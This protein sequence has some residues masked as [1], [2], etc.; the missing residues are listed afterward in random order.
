M[1]D[2]KYLKSGGHWRRW[3]IGLAVVAVVVA[4]LPLLFG[5]PFAV[6]VMTQMGIAIVFALSYNMLL[7]QGGMLSFGHAV[8]F[9]FGGYF[10]IHV[11]NYLSDSGVPIPLPFLPVFG[12]L[13]GLLLGLCLGSFSTRRAGTVFAM[14]SLGLG[15][16]MFSAGN[17]F[18]RFF[19]GEEGI[20][21]DRT[22]PVEFFGFN[23]AREIQVYYLVAFWVLAAGF[24]I[25]L[26]TRTPVGRLSNAV[27]DNEERLEFIGYSQRNI[28]LITLAGS[29]LFA[30]IAGS[31]T[32]IAY[33]ILTVEALSGHTSGNVLV[34]TFLGG[35]GVFFGPI[36][37]A[38]VLNL[39]STVL[40]TL[41]T[42][43]LL[44]LGILFLFIVLFL[45]GG[46]ASLIMMH[47]P[48][49]ATGRLKSLLVPYLMA[50]L[51]G[52]ILL[53]GL[54]GLLEMAHFAKFAAVGNTTMEFLGWVLDIET[55]LPW[56]LF[57]GLAV[58]GV[59]LIKKHIPVVAAAYHDAVTGGIAQDAKGK[60]GEAEA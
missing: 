47:R 27:R 29:G 51:Y 12:G 9:G 60:V 55:V 13:A 41:T 25:Y 44:Y 19:G 11:M 7:G 37:G 2:I 22:G 46:I 53:S 3:F 49:L 59:V 30:G 31:L 17:I 16:L 42:L 50:A 10:A 39:L 48:V 34:M 32:A 21:G 54:I 18:S 57:G 52:V 28:R 45:P 4:L 1:T 8:Y 24:L 23:F 40:S 58:A 35:V 33:E 43:W 14:I 56:A 26:Y 15:E 6:A 38:I 5:S 20:S 36:I